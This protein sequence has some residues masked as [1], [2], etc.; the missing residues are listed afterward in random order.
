[1]SK[2]SVAHARLCCQ[3][4][5]RDGQKDALYRV[6]KA[7]EVTTMGSLAEK[8]DP[9]T[10]GNRVCNVTVASMWKAIGGKA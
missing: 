6:A 3:R 2:D 7:H 5:F 8:Y 10:D 9:T 1:M 4:A